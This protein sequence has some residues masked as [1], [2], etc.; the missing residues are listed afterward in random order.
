MRL[1][2]F[3]GLKMIIDAYRMNKGHEVISEMSISKLLVL[4]IATS[5]DA[6]AAGIS[7]AVVNIDILPIILMIGSITLIL[8]Y[9]GVKFGKFIG[10]K[11]HMI[12][13]FIGGTVLIIIGVNI[14]IEH[15]SQI[16]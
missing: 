9:I 1:L 4:S 2:G 13:T 16:G 10:K 15:L 8:S 5:I 11:N 3:I 6:L 7:F 14:L 12:A